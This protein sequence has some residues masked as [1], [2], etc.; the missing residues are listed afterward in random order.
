MTAEERQRLDQALVRANLFP[1]RSAAAAAILAGVV[2][3]DGQPARK[4]GQVIPPHAALEVRPGP[5]YASRGGIKLAHALERFGVDPTGVVCLDV[6][7]STGGFTDCLLQHGATRV[8][9]VDVGYGQLAWSLRTDA[10]VVVLERV[11]AR[12]L[13]PESVPEP[14]GLAVC[15]LAFISLTKVLPAVLG[16]LAPDGAVIALV[17]PQ[18]EAGRAQVG[19]GGIVRDPRVHRQ[20]LAAVGAASAASGWP[21][22][23]LVPSPITGADGNREFLALARRGPAPT[24]L[25]ALVAGA[26]PGDAAR[27][28]PGGG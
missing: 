23:G 12:H 18:F 1:T 11:N 15:D 24:T 20:V 9:A 28:D 5:R 2:R 22:W 4:P 8:Y 25:D 16:R 6:G 27:Q 13:G 7:A 14:V 17:K 21:F 26:V 19:R 10:R 3:V